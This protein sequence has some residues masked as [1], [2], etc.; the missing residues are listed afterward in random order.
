MDTKDFFVRAS[1]IEIIYVESP[2]IIVDLKISAKSY[3]KNNDGDCP[4]VRTYF[5]ETHK[6][7]VEENILAISETGL[8][9]GNNNVVQVGS[10]NINSNNKPAK[11]AKPVKIKIIVPEGQVFQKLS[12]KIKIKGEPKDIRIPKGIFTRDDLKIIPAK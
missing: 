1:K 12:G 2:N 10:Y 8:V 4:I 11:K 9:S 7:F 5:K 3:N 6:V